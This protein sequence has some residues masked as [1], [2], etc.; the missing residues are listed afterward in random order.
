MLC[1][2]RLPRALDVPLGLCLVARVHLLASTR[3][4]PPNPLILLHFPLQVDM[5]GDRWLV[6]FPARDKI[7]TE[8]FVETLTSVTRSLGISLG[9]P[10]MIKI[11]QDRVDAYVGTLRDNYSK[12]V[13][14]GGG[15]GRWCCAGDSNIVR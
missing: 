12:Q 7:V 13:W 14:L 3:G 1:A 2:K 4:R 10:R 11:P 5:P 9:S 8:Q 15:R 6:V